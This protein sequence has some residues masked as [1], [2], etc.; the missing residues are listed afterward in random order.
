MAGRA[1]G[2][3][4]SPGRDRHPHRPG[5]PYL[6]ESVA[7]FCPEAGSDPDDLAGVSQHHRDAGD[8]LPDHRS[9]GRPGGYGRPLLYRGIDP[10]A[11]R[12][13]LLHPAVRCSAGGAA[14]LP[15]EWPDYLRVVQQ[16]GQGD[17]RGGGG[18]GGHSSPGSR[19]PA[20]AQAKG[21]VEQNH[22]TAV[23]GFVFRGGDPPGPDANG[24]GG[25]LTAGPSGRLQPGGRGPGSVSLQRD[26]HDV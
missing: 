14:P 13:Y 15:G 12:I 17:R 18:L 16:P 3:A 10:P 1:A 24:K 19:L 11:R 4:D 26:H 6:S 25:S 21:P 5:R 22:P 23:S 20:S 7:G 9:G 8:G 2:G